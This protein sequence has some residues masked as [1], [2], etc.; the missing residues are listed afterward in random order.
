MKNTEPT[1]EI[2]IEYG[3]LII[4]FG[5]MTPLL[6]DLSRFSFLPLPSD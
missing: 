4:L 3:S 2:N 1:L 5:D 6:L